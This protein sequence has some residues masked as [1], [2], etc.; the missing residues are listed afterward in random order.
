MDL[1]IVVL[2]LPT[3]TLLAEIILIEEAEHGV[4]HRSPHPLRNVERL[5][6]PRARTCMLVMLK[7]VCHSG[8]SALM[9]YLVGPDFFPSPG[10]GVE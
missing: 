8:A 3:L 6:P 4:S 10:L 2:T 7:L 1:T 5:E 9:T